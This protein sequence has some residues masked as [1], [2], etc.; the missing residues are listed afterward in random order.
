MTG[1]IQIRSLTIREKNHQHESTHPSR[2]SSTQ[3]IALPLLL[4]LTSP[5]ITRFTVS[6]LPRHE[7][8]QGFIRGRALQVPP[9]ENMEGIHAKLA[10]AVNFVHPVLHADVQFFDVG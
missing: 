7:S 1:T 6:F 8:L 4:P 5:L 10:D 2:K 3:I 9:R